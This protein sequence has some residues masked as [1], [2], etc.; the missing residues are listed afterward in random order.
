MPVAEAV[1]EQLSWQSAAAA[2]GAL[3]EGWAWGREGSGW[4][5]SLDGPFQHAGRRTWM[6]TELLLKWRTEI[7]RKWMQY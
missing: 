3:P 4:L 7:H 6:N 1:A 2:G 5:W